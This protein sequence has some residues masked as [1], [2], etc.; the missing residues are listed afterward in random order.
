MVTFPTKPV[1][2]RKT[3]AE[4]L[5][6]RLVAHV[7]RV[8]PVNGNVNRC[9]WI[10]PSTDVIGDRLSATDLLD[11]WQRFSLFFTRLID[12]YLLAQVY[13]HGQG[14]SIALAVADQVKDFFKGSS[15][16]H[17]IVTEIFLGQDLDQSV[18]IASRALCLRTNDRWIQTSFSQ[19]TLFLLVV[20]F[21]V[22]KD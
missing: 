16:R 3:D 4:H 10:P 21:F 20:V 14:K 11:D 17:R 19:P 15:L 12:E 2:K 9:R 8:S 6:P 18:I 5:E 22:F 13:D 7:E 1:S